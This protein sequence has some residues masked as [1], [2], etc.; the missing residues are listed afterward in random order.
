MME[1]NGSCQRAGQPLHRAGEQAGAAQAH[2]VNVTRP[3]RGERS[4][5]SNNAL[6]E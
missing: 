1:Q 4:E 2:S 5:Q 6:C 3:P